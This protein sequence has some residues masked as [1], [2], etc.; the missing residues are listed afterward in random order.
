MTVELVANWSDGL[1]ADHPHL[2]DVASL[3]AQPMLSTRSGPIFNT[4]SYPT[5]IDPETVAVFIAVHTNPGAKILDPFGGSGT[6]GIAARLCEKPTDRMQSI[7]ERMG[8]KPVWGP[9]D[10]VIYELSPLGTLVGKILASPPSPERFR[11]RALQLL[12]KAEADLEWMYEAID[13]AGKKGVI[14]HVVWSDLVRT[15]CCGA[16]TTYWSATVRR[17]PLRLES[18]FQCPACRSSTVIAD[19]ERVVDDTGTRA[20]RPVWLWGRTG[21]RGWDRAASDVDVALLEHIAALP[22]NH[23]V[24]D[25]TIKWGDLH[26]SGYHAG[27]DKIADLYTP[28]NLRV[29]AHL[30]SL[31]ADEPGVLGAALR[32]WLLSYNASH[33]TLMTRVVVKRQQSNFV[34]T[35]AQSGVLYISGLPVEKN[36]LAGLRRK[37]KTFVDAFS[38]TYGGEAVLDF[39]NNSSTKLDL[40]DGTID[41]VFTD[42]PF[43]DFIPYAEINQVNEAWLGEMTNWADEVIISRAQGK[44]IGEYQRLMCAVFSEVA[45]VLKPTGAATVVFHASKPEVWQALGDA[46]DANALRVERTSMLDKIQVSFKQVVHEGTTR[47]DALF[48]LRPKVSQTIVPRESGPVTPESILDEVRGQPEAKSPRRLYTKYVLACIAGGYPVEHSVSD[49]YAALRQ[50]SESDVI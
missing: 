24:P 21:A 4:F 1:T 6:T 18:E 22:V 23:A 19:C 41:Y 16:Q 46:I 36:I 20:R 42:P 8:V 14:R 9:R 38:M 40:A 5:K 10:A 44:G 13:P 31:A 2:A 33:S 49:F 26:R 50:A 48:L 29:F 45:R 17:A 12:E 3:Y 27:I 43:G 15:P 30:W 25:L 39:V 34:V 11:D 28:R 32:S 35:G 47:H 37:V 7:A